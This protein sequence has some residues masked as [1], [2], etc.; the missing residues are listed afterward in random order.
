MKSLYTLALLFFVVFQLSA[1]EGE[2]YLDKIF[3]KVNVTYN[4]Q[5][6]ENINSDNKLQKLR[7]DVFEPDGDTSR[8]RI[9]LIM[10]HGGAYWS[11]DKNHGECTLIGQDLGRMGYVIISPQYRYEPTFLSLLDEEKMVKAVARG[12]QDA[13]AMLRYIYKDVLENGNTY[14]IDTSMIFIGGA[15][16]GALNSL[17]AAYLDVE[18]T[19]PER[20]WQ[21]INE[22]GG[23]EGTSGNPGYPYKMRGVVSISGALAR[24]SMMDNNNVP[25]VSVHNTK[26]PQIPFNSGQPYSITLL[27]IIDGAN[28]LHQKA[29]A[30]GIENPFYVIP[31][32]DHTAYENL[33]ARMQPYYDSTVFYMTHF[34]HGIYAKQYQTT[35]IRDLKNL[36]TVKIFPNP[37]NGKFCFEIPTQIAAS[38][39]LSYEITDISG[40]KIQDGFFNGASNY[41]DISG[42]F[43]AGLYSFILRDKGIPIAYSRLMIHQ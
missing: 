30:L 10:I 36:Q 18:D 20:Y 37:S 32:E 26:D 35:G 40:R 7:F 1:Q 43:S 17:H 33:G 12:T 4:T 31:T 6:G 29:L 16:A 13:K 28:I 3:N 25:F 27:P 39:S 9:L 21:W 8:S 14:G 15:S 41:F 23:V 38:T 24:A 34:M 19:L 22:V 2:R 5:F 11:G 42:N